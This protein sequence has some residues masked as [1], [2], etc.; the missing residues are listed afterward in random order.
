MDDLLKNLRALARGKHDDF[1]VAYD[2]IKEITR[3]RLLVRHKKRP[4]AETPS[5]PHT[6]PRGEG[7]RDP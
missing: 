7:T 2:A 4:G 6:Y 5:L 1:G 3:L